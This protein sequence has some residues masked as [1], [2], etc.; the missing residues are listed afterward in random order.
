MARRKSES[1]KYSDFK[2]QHPIKTNMN[3]LLFE[4]STYINIIG[5]EWGS[6]YRITPCK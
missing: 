4:S 3:Y 2:K 6:K 1:I 5:V